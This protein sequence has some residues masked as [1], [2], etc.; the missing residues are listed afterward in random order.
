M[1]TYKPTT[2]NTLLILADTSTI[3]P[4]QLVTAIIDSIEAGEVRNVYSNKEVRP[5]HVSRLQSEELMPKEKLKQF[6]IDLFNRPFAD[7]LAF[8]KKSFEEV[9]DLIFYKYYV[10]DNDFNKNQELSN[11]VSTYLTS[12]YSYYYA[13][14][15]PLNG[16]EHLSVERQKAFLKSLNR[17]LTL[18]K[19]G[20]F[21][22]DFICAESNDIYN[23]YLTP[24]GAWLIVNN[25]SKIPFV[26][27]VDFHYTRAIP[28][29]TFIRKA[30][31]GACSNREW[32]SPF[33]VFKRI[34]DNR[35]KFGLSFYVYGIPF[36]EYKTPKNI[37]NYPPQG[38]TDLVPSTVERTG[39]YAYDLMVALGINTVEDSIKYQAHYHRIKVEET[40]Y[41]NFRKE[42]A[43]LLKVPAEEQDIQLSYNYA[44]AIDTT[45]IFTGS[46]SPFFM[47]LVPYCNIEK[48]QSNHVSDIAVRYDSL[49]RTLMFKKQKGS[50]EKVLN[51]LQKERC[52]NV[53]T[54]LFGSY[55]L[56]Q[57]ALYDFLQTEEDYLELLTLCLVG[58]YIN[59]SNWETYKRFLT[60]ISPKAFAYSFGFEQ[61]RHYHANILK[62]VDDIVASL[63]TITDCFSI[64]KSP[65]LLFT[66]YRDVYSAAFGIVTSDANF[67]YSDYKSYC[68]ANGSGRGYLEE[69]NANVHTDLSLIGYVRFSAIQMALLDNN[70]LLY[71]DSCGLKKDMLES[72]TIDEQFCSSSFVAWALDF[73]DMTPKSIL[74]FAA[75]TSQNVAY[76]EP[77][78]WALVIA[79]SKDEY[80][81]LTN[82]AN[83][84]FQS[85]AL[86][87]LNQEDVV[88]IS[89]AFS[90]I[91]KNC[92][93]LH[94]DFED[95]KPLSLDLLNYPDVIKLILLSDSGYTILV[96]SIGDNGIES[97]FDLYGSEVE[98]NV[99]LI[100]TSNHFKWFHYLLHSD[101]TWVCKNKGTE[102]TYDKTVYLREIIS[103]IKND[104][105]LLNTVNEMCIDL[106]FKPSES[107]L[108]LLDNGLYNYVDAGGT[109]PLTKDTMNWFLA[110]RYFDA[111]FYIKYNYSHFTDLVRFTALLLTHNRWYEYGSSKGFCSSG[112]VP[113]ERLIPTITFND[114]DGSY[115][116]GL[117][118]IKAAIDTVFSDL[119]TGD[120]HFS[121]AD[122]FYNFLFYTATFYPEKAV[123]LW[124]KYPQF[125]KY[126]G[127]LY[128]YQPLNRTYCSST[129]YFKFCD[130][131]G[132]ISL[133]KSHLNIV[134]E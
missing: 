75:L 46:S 71:H 20:A 131:N 119:E 1:E 42:Y 7:L 38:L 59:T 87:K 27:T 63:T 47:L 109:L 39:D 90:I 5:L 15:V 104:H 35:D 13:A 86:Q 133:L 82:Y 56:G 77:Y 64:S 70:E 129:D 76:A 29:M 58:K 72:V 122:T 45:S 92:T 102:Y 73:M 3:T 48:R 125:Q 127:Y 128:N 49:H 98:D 34:Y 19:E 83:K 40:H 24:I 33:Q 67:K 25:P 14:E 52:Y 60:V 12:L 44:C 107:G 103:R 91:I 37:T 55:K 94:I 16:K 79:L 2:L 116:Y 113:Y 96:K 22:F 118:I 110:H 117:K 114:T 80:A 101:S 121:Q 93:R 89:E 11:G 134:V 88:R 69:I 85:Y 126:L 43:E 108:T 53:L 36:E 50:G 6:T 61:S 130:L 8:I 65:T 66:K 23:D 120:Y 81:F 30:T 97:Y 105:L 54:L 112:C 28:F 106:L 68:L 100:R 4:K 31:V 78:T 26:P 84:V 132:F 9:T 18:K 123:N 115:T 17:F 111:K 124:L 62:T 99:L 57:K 95:I 21:N 74:T 10:A 32:H 51:D 41:V